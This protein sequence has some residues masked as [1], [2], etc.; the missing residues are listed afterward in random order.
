MA[1]GGR[2]VELHRLDPDT[3]AI[4]ESRTAK[5]DPY[6]AEDL[7]VGPD[8]SLWVGDI[9]DNEQR[10]GTVALIVVPP[11]GEPV[12]H[13][14]TYP[15][16]PHDAEALLVDA[17]GVPTVVTKSVGV[18]GIY[19]P[20]GPLHGAD[21]TPLVH[22][23]DLALPRSTTLGGPIG[24]FGSRT[25]TGGAVSAD[26][27]VVAL[28]TYTDAWL[29]A[30]PAEGGVAARCAAPRCRSRSRASPRARHWRSPRTAR[31][32]PAPRRV[33][34]WPGRSGRFPRRRRSW[35][36][37]PRSR[38]RP[39]TD[40]PADPVPVWRTAAIGAGV[41]VVIL[42]VLALA[43]ARHAARRR[44][45]LPSGGGAVADRHGIRGHAGRA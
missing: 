6:D 31:C 44:T 28:R 10:R 20:E 45:R 25:V 42:A 5:V 29:F 39:S 30:V 43:M 11:K 1:D 15:D 41:L 2:R 34:G 35:P 38:G 18:A 23:G 33:A 40:L 22:V 26:G 4:V 37:R 14:L 12:L 8:G 9:G 19:Q 17:R 24:G 21:P 16:G 27:R 13:R 7:A 36:P 3:C 32:S